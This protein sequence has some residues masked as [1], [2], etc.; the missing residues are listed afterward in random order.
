MAHA[1]QSDGKG[2]HQCIR[3]GVFTRD[4]DRDPAPPCCT[5]KV[6]RDLRDLEALDALRA[7]E[8][9]GWL[10]MHVDT[11][12]RDMAGHEDIAESLRLLLK[13]LRGSNG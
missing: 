6:D 7:S 4:D 1:W 2:V 5:S 13:L 10:L 8:A 12:A 11:T 3:C 9:F